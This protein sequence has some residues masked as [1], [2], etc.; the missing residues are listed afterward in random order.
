MSET[1]QKIS[2]TIRRLE[3]LVAVRMN[4]YRRFMESFIDQ[5][6]QTAI[7]RADQVMRIVTRHGN[8]ITDL[9]KKLDKPE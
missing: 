7:E 9:K 4:E 8:D 1:K 6:D 5:G 2:E 3:S